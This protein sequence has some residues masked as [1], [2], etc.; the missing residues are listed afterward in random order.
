MD[1]DNHV[2]V[3]RVADAFGVRGQVKI[4]SFMEK[5]ND[6][7]AFPRWIL[8]RSSGFCQSYAVYSGQI[9]GRYVNAKLAGVDSRDEALLLKGSEVLIARTEFPSLSAGEYYHFQLLG[10]QAVDVDGTDYGYVEDIMQTGA[11][12]VMVIKGKKA[13]LI[14]YTAEVIKDINL[15]TGVIQVA[16]YFDF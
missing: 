9:H 16:W 8:R 11:N 12:D 10:L 5:S 1:L 13:H 2:V 7:L 6:L 4:R 14:P 3:A 15:G